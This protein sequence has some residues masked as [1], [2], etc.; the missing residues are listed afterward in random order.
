MRNAEAEDNG[1]P[2]FVFIVS[3]VRFVVSQRLP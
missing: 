2:D 3:F 1:E